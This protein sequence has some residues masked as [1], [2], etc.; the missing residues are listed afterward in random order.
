[1]Q[2]SRIPS[3]SAPWACSEETATRRQCCA[4]WRTA[5]D[6]GD[7]NK[8]QR[9]NRRWRQRPRRSKRRAGWTSS[10]SGLTATR[11]KLGLKVLFA[12]KLDEDTLEQLEAQLLMADCGMAATQHLLD[13]LRK[14]LEA[15]GGQGSTRAML[16]DA[17][18][19]LLQPLEQPFA[20]AKESPSSIM[21]AGVNGAGKTTSIG[22]ARQIPAA[23]GAS[24]LL[25]QATPCRCGA[26]AACHLGR[27]ATTSP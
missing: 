3:E 11:D 23:A 26:R 6:V 24:V 22:K 12:G 15:G 10:K 7:N 5:V 21:I 27:S 17:L 14:A 4:S 8:R 13:D 16:V 9:R 25:A 2:L 1:M 18:T 19:D 20:V